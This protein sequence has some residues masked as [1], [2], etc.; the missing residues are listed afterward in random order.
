[1]K[2]FAKF[3]EMTSVRLIRQGNKGTQ[4]STFIK[5]Y[6]INTKRELISGEQDRL[7]KTNAIIEFEEYDSAVSACSYMAT[8]CEE[9]G[10]SKVKFSISNTG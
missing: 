9:Y 4:G 10:F 8:S 3:G 5:H 1:M 2:I 7:D 6:G